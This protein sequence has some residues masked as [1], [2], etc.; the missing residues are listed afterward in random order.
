MLPYSL[1]QPERYP[2]APSIAPLWNCW[3]CFIPV[4]DWKFT[5]QIRY[6]VCGRRSSILANCFEEDN[7]AY[8][9]GICSCFLLLCSKESFSISSLPFHLYTYL[10]IDVYFA[11][12]PIT[13]YRVSKELISN[14]TSS[15]PFSILKLLEQLKMT[16]TIR[17]G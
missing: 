10:A 1:Y 12:S 13:T 15:F 8:T 14:T 7:S 9:I 4:G 3:L 16:W 5:F 11:Y 17:G 6:N 2:I